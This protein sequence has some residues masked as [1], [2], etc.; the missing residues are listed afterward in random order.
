M[1]IEKITRACS[2]HNE[3][4]F[5]IDDKFIMVMDGA[6]S[7]E[8]TPLQPTGGAYLVNKISTCLPKLKG[9]II[10]RLDV[11]AKDVYQTLKKDNL[12][13]LKML[14]SAGLAWIEFE[15]DE[16]IVHTIGDCEA[17]IVAKDN[18]VTRIIIKDLLKLDAQALDELVK[19]SKRENICIKDCRPLINDILVKNRMM[20]NT[21]EGY[22]IFAPSNCPDFKYSTNVFLKNDIKEIYLYSDGFADAFT[23]FNLYKSAED[24][25]SK[26]V[27]INKVVNEIVNAADNDPLCNNFPRFKFI[28]DITAIKITL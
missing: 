23:T 2:L 15:G 21:P 27:D 1:K 28:D 17:A 3:D 20:M 7:L 18:K 26:S 12:T 6:T 11:V 5:I 16:V 8:K 9:D 19:V 13:N 24:L 22:S 4:S 25:F 14:P 10:D